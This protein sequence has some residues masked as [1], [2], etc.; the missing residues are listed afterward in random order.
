MKK[1]RN[2]LLKYFGLGSA[3]TSILHK[4]L[5]LNLYKSPIFIRK[6]H[7]TILTNILQK[8]IVNLK[9]KQYIRETKEFR[10]KLMKS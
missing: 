4:Q 10:Q 1:I 2:I 3:K 6:L 9:L 5:G 7:K 8:N